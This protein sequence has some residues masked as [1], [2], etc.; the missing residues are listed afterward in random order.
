MNDASYE[1]GYRAGHLQGWHDALAK[2]EQDA[3]ERSTP[4][5]RSAEYAVVPAP[6]GQPPHPHQAAREPILPAGPRPQAAPQPPAS[7]ARPVSTAGPVIATALKPGSPPRSPADLRARREKRDRQNINIILYVASLLLVAAAALFIGTS[8]PPTLRFA[9]V[10]VVTAAFYVAGMVLHARAPQLRPAA[11]AFAGTGLALVPILGLAMYNFALPNGPV[12]WLLTSLLGVAAYVAA[13]VRLNSRVLVHLS[14]TFVIS[15]AVSGVSVLGGALVWHFAGLIGVAVLLTLLSLGRPGWIPPLYI[16]PLRDVHPYLVPAVAGIATVAPELGVAEH[17]VVMAMATAYFTVMAIAVTRHRTAY[18][19][20]ARVTLTL[21]AVSL[22]WHLG[23]GIQDGFLLAAM[24]LA[25]QSIFVAVG[26]ESLQRW[27][28]ARPPAPQSRTAAARWRPDAMVTFGL[29]LLLTI[30]FGISSWFIDLFLRAGETVVTPLVV[31]V[32]AALL[33]AMVIALLLG[34]RVEAAPPAAIAVALLLSADLD[35]WFVAGLFVTVAIFWGVRAGYAVQTARNW[36]ILAT[37]CAGTAAVPFVVLAAEGPHPEQASHALLALVLAVVCQQL[38]TAVL[39]RL[40]VPAAAPTGSLAWFTG[41]GLLAF[42]ALTTVDRSNGQ[43]FTVVS[44]LALLAATLV[45]AFLLLDRVA[46]SMESPAKAVVRLWQLPEVLPFVAAGVT[47]PLMFLET[48]RGGGNSALALMLAYFVACGVKVKLPERRAAYWLL[49]RTAGTG[50]ALSLFLQWNAGSGPWVI[51]GQPVGSTAVLVLV[52]AVQL[53]FPLGAE[54]RRRAPSWVAADV[55]AGLALQLIA[56]ASVVLAQPG[57]IQLLSVMATASLSSAASGYVLRGRPAAA[58]FAPAAFLVLLVALRGDLAGTELV[59]AVFA[60]FSAVMVVAAPGRR[61]KGSYFVAARVLTAALA[62]V[63]SYD[64]AASA[65][66]VTLTLAA[67]LAAQHAIRWLMRRR[68]GDVPFQQAAVWITLAGQALLPL[69][70][71]LQPFGGNTVAADGGRWVLFVSLGLLAVS[72]VVARTLFRALGASYFVPYAVLFGVLMLGPVNVTD[73]L[74]RVFGPELLD[75]RAVAAV[76]MALALAATGSGIGR[77]HHNAAGREHWL[78]AASAT[79]FSAVAVLVAWATADPAEDWLAGIALLVLA[80]VLFA[81]AWL[82][83]L[84]WA[85]P[86]A[87]ALVLPGAYVLASGAAAG[88][89]LDL[90]RPWDGYFPWLA[91]IVP[92]AAVLY[93][94]RLLLR[95]WL[96]NQD[97]ARWSLAATAGAGFAFA[98][99]VGLQDDRTSWVG[100]VLVLITAAVASGEAPPAHR[101]PVLEMGALAVTASVQRAALLPLTGTGTWPEFFWLFQWYVILAAVLGSLRFVSGQGVAGRLILGTGAGL[102]TLSG[103]LVIFGGTGSQQLWM[104][105]AMAVLM[106]GGILLG[107]RTFVWWGAAGVAL[108]VLWAMREYTFALLALIAVGLIAFALWRLN[109][110]KPGN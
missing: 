98:A 31:P 97:V 32:A 72:A 95:P 2:I 60:A 58:W 19:Y 14:L 5:R 70:Y 100:A 42:A 92:A 12:A 90:S 3:R 63:L 13:A 4:A 21:G 9:G 1:A 39:V 71:L 54:L 68:L 34:G 62:V 43:A 38:S 99:L 46:T 101:R 78:W 96:T 22:G 59:L 104:L 15:T 57:Q 52:L 7:A 10:C 36:L 74:A 102:L 110:S 30:A 69:G 20:S 50:L 11:V 109:R 49:S 61:A 76:L 64:I 23:G 29:Q 37:R 103:V 89:A 77:R 55:G 88:S 73:R 56:A 53:V 51:G 86:P 85:C 44:G 91:G 40:K 33:T 81:V 6:E 106:L 27:M 105:V 84:R 83:S 75:G 65:T 80:L 8:L 26:R 25:G 18:F 24:V 41:A 35:R 48:G 66:V 94:M 45:A 28:P 16:R 82:E 47:A 93:L 79:A 17:S 107:E 87:A 108:C 67:V